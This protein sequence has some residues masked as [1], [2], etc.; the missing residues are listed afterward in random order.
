MAPGLYP[1]GSGLRSGGPDC[2][3]CY[4]VLDAHRDLV[5]LFRSWG[6]ELCCWERRLPS[7]QPPTPKSH[8]RDSVWAEGKDSFQ[9][10]LPKPDFCTEQ[11]EAFHP[12]GAFGSRGLQ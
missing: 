11:K 9:A 3:A 6:R 8:L 7:S 12:E 2:P 5:L 1:E 4:N 10:L